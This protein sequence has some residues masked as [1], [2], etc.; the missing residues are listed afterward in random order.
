MA[1]PS[2]TESTLPGALGEILVTIRAGGRE[3][4]RPAVVLV[5]GFK[6][7]RSWGFFPTL[8]DRLAKAGFTTITYNASGSGVD[9]AGE[10]VHPDRFGHNTYSA[11][12]ADLRTVLTALW[13]G[14]L[15]VVPPSSLGL[16]GHSRGAGIALLQA[17][18]DPKVRA[19]VSWAS[20]GAVARWPAETIADW[21]GRGRLDIMNLRTRQ[22]L[23]LYL[24]VLE[25]VEQQGTRRLDLEK[26]AAL[27]EVPWL[28]LHGEE[29]ES[30]SS[31]ESEQ[32]HAASGRGTTE[33]RIV[34]ATGHTFG[35]THPMEET[36]EPL[37]RTLRATID[38][39]VAHL[40]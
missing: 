8:A 30:V 37:E 12:L 14:E 27:I 39:F 23:P 16:M 25:E 22:V 1:T 36:P 17:A 31:T 11:E 26:A 29:D 21:K 34:Q 15:G 40:T 10:F 32:L 13:A 4:P 5:H 7:F 20:I 24:D 19:L 9:A 35:A 18:H 33:L 3:S 28:L 6:G 38:W 2:L